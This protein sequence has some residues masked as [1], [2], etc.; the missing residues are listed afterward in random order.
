MPWCPQCGAEY[1][2]DCRTCGD[3]QGPLVDKLPESGQVT[4]SDKAGDPGE[5]KLLL[6]VRSSQEA[7]SAGFQAGG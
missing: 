4:Y 5:W 1:V 2:P 3:C 7:A 6:N